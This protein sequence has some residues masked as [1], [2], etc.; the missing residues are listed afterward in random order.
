MTWVTPTFF[1]RL[2]ATG[3]RASNMSLEVHHMSRDFVGALLQ[4]NAEKGVPREQ[5]ILTIS[6]AIESAYRRIPGNED[7]RVRIDPER[8]E[9]LVTRERRCVVVVEDPLT[10]ITLD[11][12]SLIHISEPTRLGMI[13]YAVF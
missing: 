8:G 5:L 1:F 4:L 9:M 11:D 3:R 13:S 7:V 10:E 6:D 2:A 12:L